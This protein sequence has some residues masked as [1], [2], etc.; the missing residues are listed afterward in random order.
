MA[1]DGIPNT[2]AKLTPEQEKLWAD[3]TLQ[4]TAENVSANPIFDIIAEYQEELGE[5]AEAAEEAL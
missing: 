4:K 3:Q 1:L 5:A 2:S